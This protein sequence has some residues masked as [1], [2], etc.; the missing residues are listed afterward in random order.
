LAIDR[1]RRAAEL[2]PL[3]PQEEMVR[4]ILLGKNLS[5]H[6]HHVFDLSYAGRHPVDFLVFLGPGLVLECTRTATAR[7]H[8]MTEVRRRTV[9][10]EYWF[11]FIKAIYPQ[12]RCAVLVEAPNEKPERLEQT[13]KLTLKD[14][15]FFA[16]S[17]EELGESIARLLR[18]CP[19]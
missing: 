18:G 10:M 11:G 3:T 6:A 19:T 9:Y 2:T 14:A 15:D 12:I 8:A 17:G 1:L 13:L 5:F 16:R 7:G 4:G